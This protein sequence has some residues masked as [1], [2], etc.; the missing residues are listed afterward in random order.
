MVAAAGGCLAARRTRRSILAIGPPPMVRPPAVRWTFRRRTG[1]MRPGWCTAARS[2][3]TDMSVDEELA[4]DVG[5]GSAIRTSDALAPGQ[6]RVCQAMELAGVPYCV[7]PP[8]GPTP[9]PVTPRRVLEVLS[10]RRRSTDVE[11]IA[12]QLQ[13]KRVLASDRRRATGV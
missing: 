7:L 2:R 6:L 10:D 11:Q 13:Y 12:G 4:V 9:A 5:G 1:R 3:R 8:A